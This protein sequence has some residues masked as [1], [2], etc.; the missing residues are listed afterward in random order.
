[1]NA[2]CSYPLDIPGAI[3]D[4]CLKFHEHRYPEYYFLN[5]GATLYGLSTAKGRNFDQLLEF[6]RK[7]MTEYTHEIEID[8]MKELNTWQVTYEDEDDMEPEEL[9][10]LKRYNAHQAQ[11]IELKKKKKL[12]RKSRKKNRKIEKFTYASETETSSSDHVNDNSGKN[13]A[14]DSDMESSSSPSEHHRTETVYMDKD[15]VDIDTD[16][17][18][19]NDGNSHTDIIME[20]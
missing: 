16:V 15:H 20:R 3:S 14:H 1:M 7:G 13:S 11:E 17:H 6:I 18:G 10:L 4:F 5:F 8:G 19:V 12:Q 2:Q 9:A